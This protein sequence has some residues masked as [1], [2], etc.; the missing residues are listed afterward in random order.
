MVVMLVIKL[1]IASGANSKDDTQYNSNSPCL[2]LESN[3]F[4]ILPTNF[5]Y[6]LIM[7]VNGEK[8]T[9]DQTFFI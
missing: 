7:R 6:F 5:K 4:T 1:L 2:F 9:S 3:S 8:N